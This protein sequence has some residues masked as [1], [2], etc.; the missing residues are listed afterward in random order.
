MGHQNLAKMRRLCQIG[1]EGG[2]TL[3]REREP[4][5]GKFDLCL[6][7]HNFFS[8]LDRDLF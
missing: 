2:D 4:I 7:G 8:L 6:I 5:F 3:S 1:P